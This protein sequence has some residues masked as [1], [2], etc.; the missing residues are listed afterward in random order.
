MLKLVFILSQ[1]SRLHSLSFCCL[2]LF[3][4]AN[5]NNPCQCVLMSD[6]QERPIITVF[7]QPANYSVITLDNY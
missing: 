5:A 7:Q 2:N 6:K 1:T 3:C 4:T